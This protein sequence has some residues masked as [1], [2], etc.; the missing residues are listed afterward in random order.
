M[1]LFR[2][3]TPV[4]EVY[5]GV[6]NDGVHAAERVH[7]LRDVAR[8]VGITQVAD[9]NAGR[10]R[11][12]VLYRRS[13]G[14]RACMQHDGM[15]I[16]EQRFCCRAS[17]TVGAASDE[18]ASHADQCHTPRQADETRRAYLACG[19]AYGATFAAIVANSSAVSGSVRKAAHPV[20]G[21]TPPIGA[22]VPYST[23]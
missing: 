5:A 1:A 16:I 20:F 9:D 8:L 17:E 18:D 21:V 14:T 22:S 19:T 23:R 7:L 15:S 13:P 10:A 6:V 12:D 4:R 3:G 11:C 2:R